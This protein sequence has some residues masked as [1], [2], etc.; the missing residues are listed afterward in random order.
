MG[1]F[2]KP[3]MPDLP[4]SLHADFQVESILRGSQS[5]HFTPKVMSNKH[6]LSFAYMPDIV[7]SFL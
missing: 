5:S 7:L 3:Q 1:V 2:S 4:S 6:L